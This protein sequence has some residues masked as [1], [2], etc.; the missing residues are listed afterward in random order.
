M[1]FQEVIALLDRVV[2]NQ[3]GRHLSSPEIIILRGTWEGI[4]YDQMAESSPYSLNYLMR[5]IGPRLWR[6]LSGVLGE[7]IGKTNFRGVLERRT[8]SEK[9]YL[10]SPW[11]MSQLNLQ[12]SEIESPLHQNTSHN[13]TLIQEQPDT[14]IS[15][16]NLHLEWGRQLVPDWEAIPDLSEFYGRSVELTTLKQWILNDNCRIVALQGI[17]GIGKTALAG[18]LVQEIG[19]EFDQIIWRSLRSAPPIKILLDNW[20]NTLSPGLNCDNHC[21]L[22]NIIKLL[23][24]KRCLLVLDGIETILQTGELVGK[25]RESYQDYADLFKSIAEQSHQ[26]CL[27]VTGVE[28]PKEI[29]LKTG[30]VSSVRSLVLWGLEKPHA[31]ALLQSD[32]LKDAESWSILIEN[33]HGHPEALRIVAKL[34]GEVFN[35]NVHEF[36]SQE[37][38]VLSDINKLLDPLINRLSE[39]E[40]EV[41]YGLAIEPEALSFLNLINRLK[42]PICEA[43]IL[44]VMV[45]LKE[46]SL[47]EISEFD[48]NSLF[49]ING[50][51]QELMIEK[52]IEQLSSKSRKK[53]RK[54][55]PISVSEEIIDLSPN[56]PKAVKLSQWF[57]QNFEQGWQSLDILLR[58]AKH[59]LSKLRSFY[60]LRSDNIIK[61]FKTLNVGTPKHPELLALLVAITE[62]TNGKIGCQVQVLPI[63]PE[64]LLPESL[65]IR[66]INGNGEILRELACK[67]K[68]TLLVLPYFRGEPE[69]Q[70]SL[71]IIN[72]NISLTEN[73]R[74]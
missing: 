46:R 25:Y 69:D 72:Q 68:E 1:N 60:Y 13:L 9:Y 47:I 45:S 21:S 67:Q 36:L 44:E 52:L 11:E 37:C 35:G 74:I 73:F 40:K 62:E 8:L 5:D 71:Q 20:L 64:T 7:E 34:I 32:A 49:K 3:E 22:S 17:C 15:S 39:R 16:L 19:Q 4:T 28:I 27:L 23:R 56:H 59:C 48:G 30:A 29:I 6:L 63:V 54:N 61:R 26:S 41:L 38:Q 43:E 42:Y 70:F 57:E 51:I 50:F 53:S 65:K 24:E 66:L 58:P 12:T 2:L 10:S 18:K 55:Y 33:Y 14:L 31:Y